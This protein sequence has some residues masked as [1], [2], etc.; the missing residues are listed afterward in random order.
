M[1]AAVAG[2]EEEGCALCWHKRTPNNEGEAQLGHSKG[3]KINHRCSPPPR[4]SGSSLARQ[5]RPQCHSWRELFFCPTHTETHT[6]PLETK[7]SLTGKL[8][9]SAIIIII[10]Y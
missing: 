2:E 7:H 1:Q 8:L 6:L 9:E 3:E 4:A 10:Q 5:Q